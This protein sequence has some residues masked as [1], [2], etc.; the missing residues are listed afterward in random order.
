MKLRYKKQG[1]QEAAAHAVIRS[2]AGQPKVEATSYLQAE[3][4]QHNDGALLGD[5]LV[6]KGYGNAPLQISRKTIAN[7]V[8]VLQREQ[9]I[10]PI[11][12]DLESE[13]V[14]FTLEMETGTGKT[15][16]YVKTIYELNKHFGWTKFVIVV[17]SVAIR[18]GVLKSLESTS[19]HFKAEYDR[20]LS[21]FVYNSSQLSKIDSFACSPNIEVMVINMQAFNSSF[22]EAAKNKEARIIYSKRD[23]FGS[24]RPIDILAQTHPV[25]IIDEPQS[26]LGETKKSGKAKGSVGNK[27]RQAAKQFNPVLTLLYSATHRQ[28]ENM[29]FRLDALDAYNQ[30]LVKKI[31]V[32]G[33]RQEGNTAS[34]GYVYL[35]DIVLSHGNPLARLTFDKIT[36]KG[37]VKPCTQLLKEGDDLYVKSGEL[38]EYRHNYVVQRIDGRAGTVELLNGTLLYVGDVVGDVSELAM[39][40]TQIRETIRTHLE[41]ERQLFGRGIKVLSLFFID[42]VAK[43]RVYDA[44]DGDTRGLYA[45]MFEEEYL[46]VLRE[47][48]PELTDEKYL[49]YLSQQAVEQVH[50]GYFSKDKK[51]GKSIDSKG[52]KKEGG[53]SDDRDAY[54]LIMRDKERLLNMDEPTRFIFSHSALKE[55]WDNPNVFQI[56]LLR[57]TDN[58][59]RRRQEVGRGMRLC[60]NQ[61]GERQ[62]ADLLG[63]EQV[64]HT[65]VL[66]V[67]ASESYENFARGLQEEIAAAVTSRPQKVEKRFFEGKI[68]QDTL[69]NCVEV[70]AALANKVY[71]QLVKHDYV[72]DDYQLT[73]YYETEKANG[74]LDFGADLTHLVPA[75]VAELA[76]IF[77]PAPLFPQN[78]RTKRT[79]V[80]RENL[81]DAPNFQALWTRINRRTAYQ[82]DFK[83]EELIE[84]AVRALN[85]DLHVTPLRLVVETGSQK[86]TIEDKAALEQGT[87]MELHESEVK[88]LRNVRRG[89]VKYDL[90]GELVNSTGLKRTTM[91]EILRQMDGYKFMMYRQNPEE[92]LRKAANIINHAKGTLL[93]EKIVYQKMEATLDKSIFENDLPRGEVGTNAV[94]CSKSLYDI[95]VVDSMGV[96]KSFAD[97]LETAKNVQVFTKLPRGFRIN[98]PLGTY[99]PDWAIVC[100]KA[101]KTHVYLVVETKGTDVEGDL[102]PTEQMK[103][104]CA[105]LHFAA[106]SN[107]EVVYEVAKAFSEV[108]AVAD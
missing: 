80:F 97:A 11:G 37:V 76:I 25:M 18:E 38:E 87:A 96:E 66:T 6:A 69:G 22:D 62:D 90:V 21:F 33:I 7:N 3:E 51:S 108:K 43:Y 49:R 63:K 52:N 1:F 41:R 13:D 94:E 77:N 31:E 100:Q 12:Q 35:Q 83:T 65:N 10:P 102:R 70:D 42:E 29:V 84:E 72:D 30:K 19:E 105:R 103:I 93:S 24:R 23:D 67:I 91:A 98:T 14:R 89:H 2:L 86:D 64:H 58:N 81:F 34:H 57:N 45:Q 46:D 106:I 26:V 28:V 5:A 56:C 71:N 20:P 27:T 55:G 40:R 50:N 59:I 36:A 82:V 47:F 99:N 4:S 104:K 88:Y 8:R 17:P 68:W 54:D 107:D 32:K 15:Y 9:G 85:K 16:T 92:F 39:R 74:T 101:E 73:E 48:Q 53:G 95:V 44:E 79:A 61:Q 75:I 78:A 60:V